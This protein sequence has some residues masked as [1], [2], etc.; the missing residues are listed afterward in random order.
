MKLSKVRENVA[1]KAAI[2]TKTSSVEVYGVRLVMV[3]WVDDNTTHVEVSGIPIRKFDTGWPID[4]NDIDFCI[5]CMRI[6]CRSIRC[7]YSA[8]A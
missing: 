8:S 1:A 7:L 4:D 6:I 5:P 3:G 2:S